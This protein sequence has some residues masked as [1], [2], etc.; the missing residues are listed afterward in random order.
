MTPAAARRVFAAQR[1]L[2]ARLH[3]RVRG[4]SLHIVDRACPTSA[5]CAARDLAW[6]VG[7]DVYLL[8]R[9][10]RLPAANVRGLLAHELGHA[11]DDR[12]Y[13]PRS[14]RRADALAARALGLKVGYDDG[15]V[16]ALGRGRS[17]RPGN[18]HT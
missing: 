15:D 2:F 7:G 12:A 17:P 8:R 14:E 1:A 18:L 11:A 5:P 10:L 3:P 9:A 13:E 4:A 6:M 16:Q